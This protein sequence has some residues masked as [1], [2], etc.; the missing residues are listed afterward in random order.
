[1]GQDTKN[2]NNIASSPLLEPLPSSNSK[3]ASKLQTLGNIIVT[4][5]G[6]GVLGLPFAFRIAGWVAGSL[7]VAIVGISTY[8]CMLLLVMCRE[9]LASEEPLGESNTYGDLGYRSFGTPGRYLTEVIIVVAQCAGSVAYFV[10]IGQNLYSVFQGQ[11]LSMASYIFMLVPVE[12]GLSWIGSLSALAPF[13]IFA[14]VCNV[15]AMGIVVK[16]DI[17]RA[18]GKG[19]SFGQRTMITSNIGGLPFAAGMAVFCFEGFGMTLALENSM[20]DRRKFPI[21]LAQ[22]FGGITLVYILFGFC[23][24]MAFGEET[25]DI[26]TLNLPRNWSSLAVQVGLCVGLAFTLPI[27]LHPINE[28]FEGKLKIILRNN[29]DSTGLENI[30]MYIS[31]AIVV[32][33]LAVLASFV[34]EFGVYASFVGSTLCAMLSFVMPATFHLKLFGSSLPIWQKA[35][36]SIVLLSGLFFAFYGTYNTIVGV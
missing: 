6:T 11:G 36:D 23:G 33:G 19:F 35:L 22:T 12:I 17:Q 24:Y 2:Y 31:R 27:M 16:E 3:R 9:K 30:C 5:V 32:V 1:M 13:S 29:N 7:G 14:D 18:F 20:Q 8:Y 28:I 4:V 26:V 15:V 25:R 10:F 21:L 34:P